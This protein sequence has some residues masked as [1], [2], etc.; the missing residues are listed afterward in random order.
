MMLDGRLMTLFWTRQAKGVKMEGTDDYPKVGKT[1]YPIKR[2]PEAVTR[3]LYDN[4]PV[5]FVGN[6]GTIDEVCQRYDIK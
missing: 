4:M 1:E 2:A 3:M 6:K 5:H